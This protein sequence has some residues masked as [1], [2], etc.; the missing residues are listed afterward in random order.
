MAENLSHMA[1]TELT[2]SHDPLLEDLARCIAAQRL[3]VVATLGRVG[4]P[5]AALVGIALTD[6]FELVFDSVD[7]SRKILNLRRDQRV[8]LVVGGTMQD[9]RTVQVDGI[10]D[11]P[12][13]DEGE[14][15]RAA[16]FRRWP[17]GRNRLSLPG[18]TH[19]RI[20]PHWLRFSDWNAAPAVVVEWGR[21]DDG[22]F[23]RA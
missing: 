11:E 8:A 18:I 23:E 21:A 22:T 12:T 3:A 20:T 4:A 14:R 5:Q 16:Y 1:T 6:R 17:D 7:S 19:V 13:G 10:A 15:I 2:G 9:E